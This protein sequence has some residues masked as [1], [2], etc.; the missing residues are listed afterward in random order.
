VAC[1]N[2]RRVPLQD[3]AGD[4]MD[5]TASDAI[6]WF[7]RAASAILQV[8]ALSL[9]DSSDKVRASLDALYLSWNVPSHF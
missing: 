6:L 9:E 2:E 3:M 4:R 7:G 1:W 5:R 8:G